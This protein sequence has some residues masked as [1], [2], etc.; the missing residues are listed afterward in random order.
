MAPDM[1]RAGPHRGEN[2]PTYTQDP[3]ARRGQ[4]SSPMVQTTTVRTVNTAAAIAEMRR[5]VADLDYWHRREADAYREGYAAGHRSGWDVGYAHANHQIDEAWHRVAVHVRSL[6]SIPT[7]AEITAK[8]YP[9]STREE[10]QRLRGRD[11]YPL[12]DRVC[13]HCDGR[14]YFSGGVG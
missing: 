10:L 7:H 14:G 8:R 13:A 9:G 3:T 6:A 1:D 11:R 12:T 5:L 2:R 4:S